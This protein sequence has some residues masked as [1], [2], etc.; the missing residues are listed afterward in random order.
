M[1]DKNLHPALPLDTSPLEF[2]DDLFILGFPGSGGTTIT[3][4]SGIYSG[5][6]LDWGVEFYKTDA[7]I[8]HGNSGG[9]AFDANWNF[10]GVPTAGTFAETTCDD[11]GDCYTDDLPYGLIRPVE[12]ALSLINKAN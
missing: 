1:A 12:F 11:E 3:V 9:A 5:M 10:I 6:A 8:N 4:T 2:G 7:I